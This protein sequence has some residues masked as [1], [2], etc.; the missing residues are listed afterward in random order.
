M[1]KIVEVEFNMEANEDTMAA[2]KAAMATPF[3]P[4]GKNCINHG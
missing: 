3:N 4:V 2:A 1:V